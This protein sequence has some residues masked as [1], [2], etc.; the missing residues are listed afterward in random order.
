MSYIYYLYIT[1]IVSSICSAFKVP[2]IV[3]NW[4][5]PTEMADIQN[6]N[7]TINI[8]PKAFAVSKALYEIVRQFSWK[9][10][11]VVYENDDSLT[12]LNEFLRY[13]ELS[14]M[15]ITIHQLP[16]D[17]EYKPFLKYFSKTGINYFIVDCS[18]KNWL[19]F[20]KQSDEFNMTRE[21][22]VK[23]F[24]LVKVQILN[25]L[26]LFTELFLDWI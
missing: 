5:N 13:S 24:C 19:Q 8:F 2:H 6:H 9:E 7:F 22:I 3:A 15:K 23:D 10:F 12:K 25:N 17:S 18:V 1:G 11:A 4:Q 16:G 26:L 14:G 21:Y 20:I